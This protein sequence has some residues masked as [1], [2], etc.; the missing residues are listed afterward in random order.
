KHIWDTLYT[1]P[2]DFEP[3]PK[4]R[5]QIERR[6][7]AFEQDAIDW[8][9]GEA[10]AFGSLLMEGVRVRLSGQ[11]S[12]RGTFSQR[13]SVYIDHRTEEEYVPLNHLSEDQAP[14]RSLD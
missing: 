4:L 1:V 5:R 6:R 9:G 10:L 13:H 7:S 3:H 12:R 14:F 8:A 2:P 11:D